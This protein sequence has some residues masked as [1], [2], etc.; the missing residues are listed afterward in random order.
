MYF[1]KFIFFIFA[2]VMKRITEFLKYGAGKLYSYINRF[3]DFYKI[4]LFGTIIIWVSIEILSVLLT[5]LFHIL[6]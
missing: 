2:E 3:I 1:S 6:K 4:W 5:F